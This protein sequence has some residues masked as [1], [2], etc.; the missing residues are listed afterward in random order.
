MSTSDTKKAKKGSTKPTQMSLNLNS[1]FLT[2][3][4]MKINQKRSDDALGYKSNR[5]TL[6]PDVSYYKSYVK[7]RE[8]KDLSK[9]SLFS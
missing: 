7:K 2:S 5:T 1:E 9:N 3:S 6:K 4:G 8:T